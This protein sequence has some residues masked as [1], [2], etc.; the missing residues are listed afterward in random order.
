MTPA[1][2][3][4]MEEVLS[5]YARP[6]DP[7]R[8][9]VCFDESGKELQAHARPV[10]AATPGQPERIDSEYVRHGSA[11]CFLWTAPLLGRRGVT[12][13]ERRTNT[14]WALAMR[15]LV[16]EDFPD[17][18]RIVLVLDNLNTHKPGALYEAFPPEIAR[19][20]WE[21]LEIHDTPKHG[22]WLT[23]AECELSVLRRQCL[24]RRIADREALEQEVAAWVADRNTRQTRVDW[25]FTTADA[26]ITLQRLYPVPRFDK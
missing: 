3:A 15:R 16:E 24:D 23:I 1:F 11:N 21:K 2:V 13:T 5:V 4:A 20:I 8:P 10:V 25:H 26:R 12:V 19:R 18:E 17:A 7:S 6:V 22:S 9:L 14:D